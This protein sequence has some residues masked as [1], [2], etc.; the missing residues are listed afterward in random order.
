MVALG[1]R[2]GG[3][4]LGLVSTALVAHAL[5]KDDLRSYWLALSL[6]SFVV[7]VSQ[8]G[9]GQVTVARVSRS[10]ALSETEDAARAGR[11][12]LLLVAVTSATLATIAAVTSPWWAG[13]LGPDVEGVV[14]FVWIASVACASYMQTLEVLRGHHQLRLVAALSAQPLSGGLVVSAVFVLSLEALHH[15]FGTM[16]LT[17]VYVA[18]LVGWVLPLVGA[19][20]YL[21]RLTTGCS[22]DAWRIT[23]I[24]KMTIVGAAPLVASALTRF[25]ITQA[26]LWFAAKYSSVNNTAAYGLASNLVKYVSAVNILIGALIPGVIAHY[27]ARAETVALSNLARKVSAYGFTF[28]LAAFLGFIACGSRIIQLVAGVGFEA[29]LGPL[30][31]LSIG[32]VVNAFFGYPELILTSAGRTRAVLSSS[33]IASSVTLCLLL[34][35]TPAWDILGAAAASACGLATYSMLM[36]RSCGLKLGVW[37][38][39]SFRAIRLAGL[40]S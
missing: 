7:L 15:V 4:V 34:V 40:W 36:W 9:I 38:H 5:P 16:T 24:L 27:Y 29:S 11:V 30:L 10:L 17:Y 19:L 35:L 18:L 1:A 28:A 33:L 12:S 20:A 32:H 31:I 25:V 37:C 2:A 8:S 23:P 3:I 26:D 13:A 39:V 6:I 14:W 21:W 22:N